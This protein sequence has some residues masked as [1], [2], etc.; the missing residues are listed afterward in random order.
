MTLLDTGIECTMETGVLGTDRWALTPVHGP[1][2][3][4]SRL[5]KPLTGRE[6]SKVDCPPLFMHIEQ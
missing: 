1:P 4:G 3:A 2:S 5:N 6:R